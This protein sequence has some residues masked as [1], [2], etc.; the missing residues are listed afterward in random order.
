[1]KTKTFIFL[2]GY[3]QHHIEM[4]NSGWGCGYVAIPCHYQLV[5][6]HFKRLAEESE[7]LNF[8]CHYLEIN[9]NQ[10]INYTNTQKIKNEDYLIV[11]FD[12]GHSYNNSSN[13]FNWILNETL[14]LQE[15]IESA[16]NACGLPVAEPE[17]D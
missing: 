1:M 14:E 2:V 8:V 4:C 17:E 6:N 3:D 11:G 16:N 5:K 10:E 13:D 12:T 9:S 7:Y 15:L